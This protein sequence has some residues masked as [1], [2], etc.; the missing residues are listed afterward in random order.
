MRN[1][2]IALIV[3]YQ[4]FISPRKGFSCAHRRLHS[5]LSCSHAIRQI[6]E[7]H[8]VMAGYPLIR[9]RFSECRQAYL[10]LVAEQENQ[11][12]KR[13]DKPR[14]PARER[15]GSCCEPGPEDAPYCLAE[16]CFCFLN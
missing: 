16:I 3:F 10:A 14:R 5:G 13:E 2:I 11:E 8:G 7:Q 15:S 1:L 12:K 6:I 9:L 4:R